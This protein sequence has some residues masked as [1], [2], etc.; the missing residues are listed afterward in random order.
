MKVLCLL[1]VANL[2]EPGKKRKAGDEGKVPSKFR[3]VAPRKPQ[4]DFDKLVTDAE[5]DIKVLHTESLL[6]RRNW[7]KSLFLSTEPPLC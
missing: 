2:Q 3:R 7:R 1:G 6:I 4:H 5:T